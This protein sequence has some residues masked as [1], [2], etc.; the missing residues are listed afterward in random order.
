MAKTNINA[1]FKDCLAIENDPLNQL[2]SLAFYM[3]YFGEENIV[4]IINIKYEKDELYKYMQHL[5]VDKILYY[6][7]RQTGTVKILRIQEKFVTEKHSCIM[8]EYQTNGKLGWAIDSKHI[9]EELVFFMDGDVY[10]INYDLLRDW[11]SKNLRDF[12]YRFGVCPSDNI[13]NLN[14]NVPI[15]HIKEALGLENYDYVEFKEY[16]HIYNRLVE[17]YNKEKNESMSY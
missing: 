12:R 10:F 15:F 5:G 17:Q 13:D 16:E 14:V 3:Y 1:S 7:C 9:T 6:R 4:K 11:Y 8:L 2:K